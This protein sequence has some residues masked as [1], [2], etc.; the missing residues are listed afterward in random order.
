MNHVVGEL[1]HSQFDTTH[2]MVFALHG[3]L[4]EQ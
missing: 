4:Y 1:D 3:T 2:G